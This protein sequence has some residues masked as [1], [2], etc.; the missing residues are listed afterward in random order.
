MILAI[1]AI[2][3]KEFTEDI[4]IQLSLERQ[5]KG[6]SQLRNKEIR[7][8]FFFVEESL[9]LLWI[10]CFW[11]G[12]EE[13]WFRVSGLDKSILCQLQSG[14]IVNK[15]IIKQYDRIDCGIIMI[16]RMPQV[17]TGQTQKQNR[18]LLMSL[19][20]IVAYVRMGILKL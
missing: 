9:H 6:Q 15:M 4:G 12:K 20:S 17:S 16:S 8:F 2:I 7:F 18:E 19:I 14:W 13:C 5:I 11:Q 3:K 10:S 1:R